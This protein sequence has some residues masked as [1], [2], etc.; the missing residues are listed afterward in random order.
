MLTNKVA[1]TNTSIN[2]TSTSKSSERSV[3][4]LSNYGSNRSTVSLTEGQIIKGEVTDLRNKEVS[5]TMEDNTKVTGTLENGANLSIGQPAAFKVVS[6]SPKGIVLEALPNNYS[7]SENVTIQKALE[8]AGLPKTERNQMIVHELL[9]NKMSINKQSIQTVLQQS[10]MNKDISISTLVLM[11]KLSI[12]ITKQNATQFENYR[13]YEHRLVKE[14]DQIASNLPKLLEQL[15][16]NNSASSVADFGNQLLS[17]V[18]NKEVLPTNPSEII[19]T[20]SFSSPE[21]ASELISILENF[22]LNESQ[23]QQLSNGSLPLRNL[24]DIINSSM[25][26]AHELDMKNLVAELATATEDLPILDPTLAAVT[27]ETDVLLEIPKIMDIFDNPVIQDVLLQHRTLQRENGELA[28][29]LDKDERQALHDALKDFP[30]SPQLKE[31]ILSGE[32]PLKEVL[33]ITKNVLSFTEPESV[34]KLFTTKE[35]QSMVKE[36]ILLNWTLTPNALLKEHAVEEF[37]D[38][39]YHQLSQL[40]HLMQATVT[41]SDS[42]ALSNQAGQMRENIDFMK[43]LNDFFPYVQLPLK[44][45]DTNIHSDL[46]VYTK[47]NELRNHPDNISVLLHLDMDHLGPLDIHLTLNNKHI[48]SKF[49][50]SDSESKQLIENNVI[51]LQTALLAKGYSLSYEALERQR[52]IDLV[53]DFIAQ[54]SPSTSLKRYTFDIRA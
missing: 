36:N 49:Y 45:K 23:K 47:K 10:L 7:L 25:E 12:P 3:G 8:E 41:G 40:E 14:I 2:Q 33:S 43:T 46:Y 4:K 22:T 19:T 13:N 9:M 38:K 6:I 35:F 48:S 20:A 29:F 11:N 42:A 54:D 1:A 37:Y 32:A 52:D 26:M 44:L 5:V 53:D 51:Q 50:I 24:V 18:Q 27:T 21:D 15:A 16:K 34:K 17:L 39:M 28:S 30:I 31:K